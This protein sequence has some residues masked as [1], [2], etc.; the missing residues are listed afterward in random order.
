MQK[1]EQIPKFISD[2]EVLANLE[3][4]SL[5]S[6]TVG[7]LGLTRG[8]VFTEPPNNRLLLQNGAGS[9]RILRDALLG[10]ESYL[11]T[12]LLTGSI[13][14]QTASL[15][16]LHR[17]FSDSI[18]GNSELVLPPLPARELI[19]SGIITNPKRIAEIE[20]RES[21]RKND[22]TP[23]DKW[24]DTTSDNRLQVKKL[25]NKTGQQ[26]DDVKIEGLELRECVFISETY[27]RSLPPNRAGQIIEANEV[28][29]FALGKNK[30]GEIV[31]EKVSDELDDPHMHVFV[32]SP[33]HEGWERALVDRKHL[34]SFE[35]TPF[36]G[37]EDASKDDIAVIMTHLLNVMEAGARA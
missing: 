5:A 14:S 15:F 20:Q 17:I 9:I 2:K 37:P 36:Q 16:L 29:I 10:N 4:A 34:W 22:W 21:G 3:K 30:K 25:H 28:V 13:D 27:T 12:D 7:L 6:L 35:R 26:V 1:A 18:L 24:V 23:P 11:T 31:M 8:V 32:S 19:R 33:G